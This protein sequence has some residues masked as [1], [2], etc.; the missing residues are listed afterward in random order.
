DEHR[1]RGGV[2]G[3]TPGAVEPG[4]FGRAAVAGEAAR[5]VAGE[6][7]DLAG[8]VD[9]PDAILDLVGDVDVAVPVER[10]VAGHREST[11]EVADG[12]VGV[13]PAEP[14]VVLV[15]DVGAAGGVEGDVAGFVEPGLVGRAAVAREAGG[16]GAGHGGDDLGAEVDPPDP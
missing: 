12:P 7:G 4:L 15:D 10:H 11:G 5:A 13:D 3:D 8:R 14:A 9:A 2:E 6:A 16:A 1:V